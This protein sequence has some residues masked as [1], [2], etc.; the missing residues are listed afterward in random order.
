MVFH[1]KLLWES[2]YDYIMITT[3]FQDELGICHW[4]FHDMKFIVTLV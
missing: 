2:C 3:L 4:Y 1:D